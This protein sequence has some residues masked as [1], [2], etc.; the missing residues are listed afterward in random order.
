MDLV[1]T[2]IGGYAITRLLSDEGG[3]GT[4]WE[5]QHGLSGKR[6]VVKV[7]RAELLPRPEMVERFLREGQ[8]GMQLK[9]ERLIEIYDVAQLADGRPYILMEFLDGGD[10]ERYLAGYEKL[11]PEDALRVIAQI[12]DGLRV[13]HAAGIVHR[14]LKPSN[15]YLVGDNVKILDFGLAKVPTTAGNRLTYAGFMA[16]SAYYV[17][18]EQIFDFANADG[19]ADVFAL[20][21][22]AVRMLAGRLPFATAEDAGQPS[23]QV[24]M[25][26]LDRQRETPHLA[27]LL[28]EREAPRD[29]PAGWIDD[30][31]R[32]IAF[33]VGAR[34]QRPH[35]LPLALADKLPGGEDIVRAVARSLHS[36]ADPSDPTR[37]HAGDRPLTA[38]LARGVPPPAPPPT[39]P[40]T[41]GAAA[42]AVTS[43]PAVPTRRRFILPAVGGLAVL[44]A[45]ALVVHRLGTGR[46]RSAAA[47]APAAPLALDTSSTPLALDA[48]S[49]APPEVEP[50]FHRVRIEAVP[51]GAT[52]AVDGEDLG[53]SPAVTSVAGGATIR[54]RAELAGHEPAEQ[55]LHIT[56][57]QTLRL[58]LVAAAIPEVASPSREPERRRSAR[59]ARAG[60]G[61]PP[62]ESDSEQ[63]APRRTNIGG[64]VGPR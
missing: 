6:A 63:P 7:I 29:M 36:Q 34:F 5:A 26:A 60:D 3:M 4:V 56:E 38:V 28:L 46:D 17:A 52:I 10:L 8:A 25:R 41:H 13:L 9:H 62:P 20:A 61:A 59:R 53:T 16:G 39:G 43:G 21:M 14:D 2:R 31:E 47:P 37:K 42:G 1:G 19:R 58:V 49:A 57:P 23:Q 33:D 15:V 44:A 54:V 64:A 22:I 12:A 11:C 40:T 32:G 50:Q 51:P 55:V 18:P 35:D 45:G 27:R 24:I 48:G 30:L